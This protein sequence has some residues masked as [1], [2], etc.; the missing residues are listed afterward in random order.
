MAGIEFT[1]VPYKGGGD[2]AVA[3]MG[4][5]APLGSVDLMASGSKIS[6]GNLK[7]LA[8]MAKKR[9]SAFPDIPTMKELG[10]NIEGGFFNMIIVPKNTPDHVIQTLHDAFKK[11]M[12]DPELLAQAKEVG[13]Q[14]EYAGPEECKKRIESDYEM[15]GEMYIELGLKKN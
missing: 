2:A 10:Y 1:A 15:I 6:G 14:Y 13:L 8:I 9:S 12:E 11:A 5:H 4:G 7:P 3:V